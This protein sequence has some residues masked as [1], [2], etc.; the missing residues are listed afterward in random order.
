MISILDLL[1]NL[2]RTKQQKEK[3][4]LWQL[5]EIA[6]LRFG[7]TKLGA[8][9]YYYYG[10]FDEAFDIAEKNKFVGWRMERKIDRALNNKSWRI[11]ANDK[12]LFYALMAAYKMPYPKILAIYHRTRHFNG[13]LSLRTTEDTD[14]FVQNRANYPFFA[15]P[16]HGTYGRGVL[17]A[18]EWAD[19]TETISLADGQSVTL[20]RFHAL[21]N[22]RWT[23]GYVFQ[24]VLRPHE[25]IRKMCGSRLTS[26]RVVVLL[27]DGQPA[28][29]QTTWKIPTGKNMSDNFMHGQTGNLLGAVESDSGVVRRV[30]GGIGHSRKELIAHPDTGALLTGQRL[31]DWERLIRS[32]LA[33]A[34]LF[35]SLRLQHWDVALSDRGPVILEINVEGSTDLHQLAAGRGFLT[36]RLRKSLAQHRLTS[37]HRLPS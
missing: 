35:P 19:E 10:L 5:A 8:S 15:K 1:R 13:A 2:H 30:V 26:V 18:K 11:V 20:P 21:V 7:E 34:A 33:G 29:L 16:V 37:S 12:L 17:L 14:Q 3:S 28:V 25:A 4:V 6:R 31:P 9:E 23:S 32:C 36:D 24:E 27:E 22:E